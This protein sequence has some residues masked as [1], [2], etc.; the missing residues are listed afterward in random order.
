M[1]R[2]KSCKTFTGKRHSIPYSTQEVYEKLNK[3][4]FIPEGEVVRRGW[5]WQAGSN[6]KNEIVGYDENTRAYVVTITRR[7]FG[8][9]LFV[10]VKEDK[11]EYRKGI[12]NC[13]PTNYPK[14][15]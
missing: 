14:A 3:L 6:K 10:P 7:H 12:R 9:R 1:T 11:E 2:K 13:F 15:N 5:F 4:E 8:Q